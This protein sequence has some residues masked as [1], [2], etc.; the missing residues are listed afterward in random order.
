MRSAAPQRIASLGMPK[1]RPLRLHALH[2][3]EWI[4]HRRN[5]LDA[6]IGLQ[7]LRQHLPHDSGVLDHHNLD[8]THGVFR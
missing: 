6:G 7:Q 2:R 5:D 4:S 8:R 1:T 3:K